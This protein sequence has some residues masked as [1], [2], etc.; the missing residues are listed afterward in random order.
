MSRKIS[1]KKLKGVPRTLLLPLRGRYL[2]TKDSKGIIKDPKSVEII[3]SLDHDFHKEEIPWIGQVLFSTRT[4]ILDQA[5]TKFLTKSPDSVVVNLGCG[6]DTRAH[7][8]DNGKVHWYDLDLSESIDL[9][10][11]FLPETDRFKMIAKSVMDFSWVEDIPKDKKTLFI[12]EGL[13]FYFSKQDVKKIIFAIKD[14]FPN[15]EIVF[16]AYSP[17]V[18]LS[19]YKH[20]HFRDACSMFKWMIDKGK[21]LEKW[22]H[23]IK[24]VDQWNYFERHPSR[25]R[26]IRFFR[27]IPFIG[28]TMKIVHLRFTP[29]PA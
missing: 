5:V 21:D 22:H 10:K 25:W 12:A 16:E 26:W 29:S 14:Y 18:K 2:E 4:E 13:F 23:Q 20:K 3:D 9:R 28:R 19:M 11:Q 27:H 24:F 17:L 1:L 6:L 7:R 15:S 8:L